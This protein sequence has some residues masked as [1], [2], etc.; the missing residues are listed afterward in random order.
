MQGGIGEPLKLGEQTLS[1]YLSRS[2]AVWPMV[3]I[4]RHERASRSGFLIVAAVVEGR[5]AMI[6]ERFKA[7][8]IAVHMV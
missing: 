5:N 3:M 4:E 2:G 8:W 7:G 1:M 6:G